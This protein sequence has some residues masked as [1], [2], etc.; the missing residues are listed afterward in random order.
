MSADRGVES[1]E[2]KGIFKKGMKRRMLQWQSDFQEKIKRKK[3]IMEKNQDCFSV[4][5]GVFHLFPSIGFHEC[6]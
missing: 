3:M 2:D 4:S 1:G 6:M 5:A